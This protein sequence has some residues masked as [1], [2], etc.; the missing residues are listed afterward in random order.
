L[1]AQFV[2]LGCGYTGRRIAARLAERGLNVLATARDVERLRGL[3]VTPVRLV[4]EEE[5]TVD[6]LGQLLERGC[7]VLYSIPVGMERMTSVLSEKAERLVYLSTTG[8]YGAQRD[9]NEQTPAAPRSAREKRRFAQELEVMKRPWSWLILRAAAIYGPDRGVYTAMRNGTYRMVGNGSNY[10]SRI[11]V[12]DLAALAEAGLFS[13]LTG[14]WP[15][16]DLEPCT[17]YEMASYCAKLLGIAMPESVPAASEEDTR[18]ADRRVN[19]RAIF[20]ALHVPLHYPS[21][22]TGIK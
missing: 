1:E 15:V 5:E 18:S 12:E 19:G 3:R 8:V 20:E 6:S 14:A 16:A 22:K 9:V 13:D 21:Y 2:I 4:V 7:R 17:A 11:H 10:V